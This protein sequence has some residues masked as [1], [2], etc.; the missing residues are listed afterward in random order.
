MSYLPCENPNCRSYGKPHPNCRCHGG[1]AKGGA[2]QRFCAMG[3]GH[4]SDCE[5]FADGGGASGTNEEPP[6]ISQDGGTNEEPSGMATED[7]GTNEEPPGS[8]PTGGT[9]DEPPALE[10]PGYSL[11]TSV[12][13]ALHRIGGS[14]LLQGDNPAQPK[15]GEHIS[16]EQMHLLGSQ[17]EDAAKLA[18]L[19]TGG[20]IAAVGAEA[21]E[22]LTGAKW[23][24]QA[25]QGGIIQAGDEVSDMLMGDKPESAVGSATAIGA[26]FLFNGLFGFGSGKLAEKASIGLKNLAEEKLA[27]K[28]MGFLSGLGYAA[29]GGTDARSAITQMASKENPLDTSAFQLGVK[30]FKK[31]GAP[32]GGALLGAKEGWDQDGLF[33]ALIG[34][35]AGWTSGLVANSAVKSGAKVGAPVLLWLLSKGTTKGLV[36]GIDH[37]AQVAHGYRALDKALGF[38]SGTTPALTSRAIDAYGGG[39]ALKRDLDTFFG[40]GGMTQSVQEEIY[41]MN[42]APSEDEYHFAEGGEVK[43]S[44]RKPQKG[45]PKALLQVDDGVALHYPAQNMLINTARGRVSNY[46]MGLRPQPH[47]PK[48][49]FDDAP[50]DRDQ[51]RTYDRALT[52]AASPLTVLHEI[53]KGTMEPEHIKHL[54]AMYPELTTEIQKRVTKK[55]VEAQLSGKKPPYKVRQGLSMLVGAPL[56]GEMTPQSIQAAQAVFLKEAPPPPQ[57]QKGS[58]G[59]GGDKAKLAKSDQAFL[60]G[61]QAR[62]KRSQRPT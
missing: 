25:I 53:A 27:K 14:G 34:A 35:G 61:S 17:N 40:Q 62:E 60:T 26:N 47:A 28:G 24:Q 38:V 6:E 3:R 18:A 8:V 41:E 20:G 45:R 55:I 44:P 9:D 13:D 22:A 36:Q 54:T 49:P 52:I 33:G 50:D 56:S 11:P 37:A 58:P 21:S 2:V 12:G 59:S 48:L 57:G 31:I 43:N 16:D 32:S 23:L 15:D 46:M 51:K 29:K 1:L 10:S 4:Q 39:D 7:G 5:Y 19:V 30:Y 42:G